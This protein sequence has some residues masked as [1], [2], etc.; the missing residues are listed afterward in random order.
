MFRSLRLPSLRLPADS[1]P[2]VPDP[3]R[4]TCDRYLTRYDSGSTSGSGLSEV[5]KLRRQLAQLQEENDS[6]TERLQKKGAELQSAMIEIDR[7][8]VTEVDLKSQLA[9]ANSALEDAS[10][11]QSSDG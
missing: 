2:A 11:D 9:Q 6:L 5:R 8:K 7:R 10:R 3:S 4:P 1:R